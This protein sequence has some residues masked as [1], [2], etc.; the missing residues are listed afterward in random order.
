MLYALNARVAAQ[1]KC[2]QETAEA[3]V[4]LLNYR[5]TCPDAKIQYRATSNNIIYIHSNASYL[6]K[7]EA[8][9]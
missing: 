5:A 8:C 9:S 1:S 3:L 6:T 7:S 4:H 2:T